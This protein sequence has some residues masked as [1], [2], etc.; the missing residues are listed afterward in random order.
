V[1]RRDGPEVVPLGPVLLGVQAALL[2]LGAVIAV[3][4]GRDWVAPFLDVS[5]DHLQACYAWVAAVG[6]VLTAVA[7]AGLRAARRWP[8][9]PALEPRPPLWPSA[10]LSLAVLAGLGTGAYAGL[11]NLVRGP[12]GIHGMTAVAYFG[13]LPLAVLACTLCARWSEAVARILALMAGQDIGAQLAF[14]LGPRHL[15]GPWSE[16]SRM[17][18]LALLLAL[19]FAAVYRLAA[20]RVSGASSRAS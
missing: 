6:V 15:R 11:M 20:T 12:G 2:G 10:W 19:A 7:L 17:D 16:V 4:V 3:T 1:S 9:A 5:P 13:L 8:F 18:L 14:A